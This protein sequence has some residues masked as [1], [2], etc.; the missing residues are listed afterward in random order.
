[1]ALAA[2]DVSVPVF[3]RTLGN[4]AAILVKGAAFAEAR[5]IDPAVLTSARLAPASTPP[6]P[7]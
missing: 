4:L 2:Y 1:M 5:S 6:S 7:F 3:I